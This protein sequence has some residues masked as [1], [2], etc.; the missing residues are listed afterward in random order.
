[1][2]TSRISLRPYQGDIGQAIIAARERRVRRQLVSIPTGTG[3][4]VC[5]CVLPRLLGVRGATVIAA[6]RDILVTQAERAMRR[7]EPDLW[8]D[9]EKAERRASPFAKIVVASVQSLGKKRLAEFIQ[10]FPSQIELLVIDE[11]HHATAPSYRSLIEGVL[12]ANPEALVVGFTATPHRGDG[13]SL[14]AV[15]DEI[16]YERDIR[17]ATEEGWLVPVRSFIV[18]SKTSLDH[19]KLTKT[20]FSEESLSEAIDVDARN[21]LIVSSYR[22]HTPGRLAVVFT[23][24]V[25]H[26]HHVA[27]AFNAAGVPA[28]AVSGNT[29]DDE[30]DRIYAAYARRDLLV[31]TCCQLL[32]EGIGLLHIR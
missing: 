10:R 25:A 11:A 22:K 24:T 20:D 31:L 23:A 27:E 12:E 32:V 1:M 29:P 6:N 5:F 4:T 17:W 15:W 26:A 16:V 7:E 14:S 9:V 21:A 28:R 8:L 30:R 2:G 19:V 3:K 18:K 13:A